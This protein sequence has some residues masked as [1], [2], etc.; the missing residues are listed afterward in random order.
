M[1]AG[2]RFGHVG[3]GVGGGWGGGGGWGS[4]G[5]GGVGLRSGGTEM[6]VLFGDPL[7]IAGNG[8]DKVVA[9]GLGVMMAGPEPFNL[10][11]DGVGEIDKTVWSAVLRPLSVRDAWVGVALKGLTLHWCEMECWG[12]LG[13]TRWWNG[14]ELVIG[15]NGYHIRRGALQ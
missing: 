10:A 15:K 12:S 6:L 11:G 5:G 7:T 8:V 3:K 14:T 4:R 1:R 9:R 2:W 13:R